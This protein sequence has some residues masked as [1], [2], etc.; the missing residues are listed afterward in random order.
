MSHPFGGLLMRSGL[1]SFTAR[2]C[3]H[4]LVQI[5]VFCLA[6]LMRMQEM[7]WFP[8][9]ATQWLVY[10]QSVECSCEW[11]SVFRFLLVGGT[12]GITSAFWEL[13]SKDQG[14]QLY[15]QLQVFYLFVFHFFGSLITFWLAMFLLI[16]HTWVCFFSCISWWCSGEN[17]HGSTCLKPYPCYANGPWCLEALHASYPP[18]CCSWYL[19]VNISR[20][21]F[22][23]FA[24]VTR[25]IGCFVI[26]GPVHCRTEGHVVCGCLT[27]SS[28]SLLTF[29]WNVTIECWDLCWI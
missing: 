14:F 8:V 28:Q 11:S 26:Q 23:C 2:P 10:C 16:C 27:S 7:L 22:L 17:L 3:K 4:G 5:V 13:G 15:V 29:M 19:V 20:G 9:L 24:F 6:V 1:C 12:D 21:K 25:E 18:S